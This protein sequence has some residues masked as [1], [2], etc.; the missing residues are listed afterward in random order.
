[1]P[2][3]EYVTQEDIIRWDSIIDQELP[4]VVASNL[5]IKEVCYAGQW[6]GE[7]LKALDCSEEYIVRI[8]FTAGKLSFGRDPWDVS[9]T[10]LRAYE[11][12]EL[13]YESDPDYNVN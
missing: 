7:Q 6:L 8:V 9:V 5:L 4:A 12:N 11:L 10:L 2:R 1:M 3:P 13:E